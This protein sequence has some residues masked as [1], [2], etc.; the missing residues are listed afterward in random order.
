MQN[1]NAIKM[2][3]CSQLDWRR[4][5]SVLLNNRIKPVLR[6]HLI[7]MGIRI[8][9][10]E[11]MRKNLQ[12]RERW[13]Q[14]LSF[15]LSQDEIKPSAPGETGL[16]IQFVLSQDEIKPSA[17]GKMGLLIKFCLSQNEIKPSAPGEM[18]LLIQFVLSQDEI[19]PSA[20]GRMGL[21]IKFCLFQNEIE[22]S[23]PGEMGLIQFVRS[24]DEIDPPA[25]APGEMGLLCRVKKT[26][27][28]EIFYCDLIFAPGKMGLFI[29]LFYLR[30]KLNLQ[31]KFRF[32]ERWVS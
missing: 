20:P 10:A 1:I 25:L 24:Q 7:L 9:K 2:I 8:Q 22:P 28:G 13:V 26:G 19:K 29:V 32:R 27:S 15:V 4:I 16:L 3:V 11:R 18:G 21:L 5:S 17:P 14:Y 6:I 23:A 30:M 31:L 12:L